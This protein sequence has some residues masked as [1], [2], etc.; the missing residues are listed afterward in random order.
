M[1]RTL[2]L[3]VVIAALVQPG[4][5]QPGKPLRVGFISNNGDQYWKV[6]AAGAQKAADEAKAEL[7]FQAPPEA[8]AEGQTQVL[9]KMIAAKIDGLAISLVDFD[10]Q[11]KMMAKLCKALPVAFYNCDLTGTNRVLAVASDHKQ[12][13]RL[14]GQLIREALPKGA[15]IVLFTGT[16]QS[17]FSQERFKALAAELGIAD[18][19]KDLTSKDKKY[20]ML[21]REPV[22]DGIDAKAARENIL[23]ALQRLK[24]RPNPCL[25]GLWAYHTPEIL[26]AAKELDMA[27]KVT[28]IG[29]EEQSA[30][31]QGIDDGFIYATVVQNP[32][33]M[34]YKTIQAVLAKAQNRP[35]KAP[36]GGLEWIP[37]RIVTKAGGEGRLK[38]MDL[39]NELSKILAP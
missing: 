7:I 22:Q 11:G 14:A 25:V 35:V 21:F 10:K 27:G 2:L 15:T 31:L 6:V 5:A 39:Y 20:R 23:D 1:L 16:S 8:S 24:D 28:I 29:F 13:G 17:Y 18:P 30:T 38:A 3:V 36:R 19:E 32:Q 33:L 4:S 26:A 34:G 9:Q 37:H 12:G